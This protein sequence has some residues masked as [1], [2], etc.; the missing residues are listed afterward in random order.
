MTEKA[1]EYLAR[2]PDCK[3]CVM[4]ISC[5]C[6]E[7]YFGM[8]LIAELNKRLQEAKCFYEKAIEIIKEE[9]NEL[10][11]V[12]VGDCLI[13]RFVYTD[14]SNGDGTYS[15]DKMFTEVEPLIKG[16]TDTWEEIGDELFYRLNSEHSYPLDQNALSVWIHGVKQNIREHYIVESANDGN[17]VYQKTVY[18]FI[19]PKPTDEKG[20]ELAEKP[21]AFYIIERPENGE[22]K[23]CILNAI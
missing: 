10:S 20:N 2:I 23:S 22:Y 5:D 18:G 21:T 9:T 3:L 1:C 12:M 13:H 17:G 4:C 6:F 19:I 7:Y 16:Y 14:A 8:G 15:F 11:M